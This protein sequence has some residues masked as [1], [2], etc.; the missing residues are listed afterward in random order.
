MNIDWAETAKTATLAT[1]MVYN[2]WTAR[3]E[4]RAQKRGLSANPTRCT[5]HEVT[6]GRIDERLN[7]LEEDVKE[8]RA[9]LK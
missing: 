3:K 5:E 6:L 8:I 4:W 7:H 1:L 2:A 9:K